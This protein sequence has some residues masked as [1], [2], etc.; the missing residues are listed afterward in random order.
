MDPWK[1]A[2]EKVSSVSRSREDLELVA[3]T[4]RATGR[5]RRRP[6]GRLLGL[7]PQARKVRVTNAASAWSTRAPRDSSRTTPSHHRRSRGR[8]LLGDGED[9]GER[10]GL[11]GRV[12]HLRG[13]RPARPRRQRR[14]RR[15]RRCTRPPSRRVARASRADR[16]GR[17]PNDG[18]DR[19]VGAGLPRRPDA[20]KVLVP[21]AEVRPRDEELLA[22]RTQPASSKRGLDIVI[23]SSSR[24]RPTEFHESPRALSARSPT[25]ASSSAD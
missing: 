10:P 8:D 2:G 18:L 7:R 5:G 23:D 22:L 20:V 1:I 19:V 4:R 24:E 9:S 13:V 6:R 21:R 12:R 11:R 15:A 17:Q 14:R 3:S 16:Q 25:P